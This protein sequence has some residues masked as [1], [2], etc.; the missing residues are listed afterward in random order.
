[1]VE[2]TVLERTDSTMEI[3]WV[4]PTQAVCFQYITTLDAIFR[5]L[6]LWLN[7]FYYYYLYIILYLFNIGIVFF[8]SSLMAFHA[9]CFRLWYH[10]IRFSTYQILGLIWYVFMLITSC[11]YWEY[12]IIIVIYIESLQVFFFFFKRSSFSLY[13][14]GDRLSKR[15]IVF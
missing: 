13:R 8:P 6:Q 15:V 12:I 9:S 5:Y 10:N 2:R 1:M 14:E 4:F 11:L 7:I 3:F